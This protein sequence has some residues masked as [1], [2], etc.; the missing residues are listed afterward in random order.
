MEGNALEIQ[1]FVDQRRQRVEHFLAVHGEQLVCQGTIVATWRWR[2][3]RRLGPYFAL[4]CRS[5]AG[6]QVSV[7]LGPTSALV[8]DVTKT[9]TQLQADLQERRALDRVWGQV[10]DEL[11]AAKRVLA[12]ELA[13][14][15]LYLKGS[16][17]RGWARLP[18]DHPL[19]AIGPRVEPRAEVTTPPINKRT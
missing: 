13:Q 6:R 19:S 15:G 7:Y 4:T 3:G 18:A 1:T 9:L 14:V 8:D 12:A 10:R 16:E 5:A 2:G 11:K 17:I